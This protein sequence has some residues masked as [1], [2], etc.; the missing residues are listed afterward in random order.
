MKLIMRLKALSL[1]LINTY[2]LS[3]ELTLPV[4]LKSL[5]AS[6]TASVVQ[7]SVAGPCGHDEN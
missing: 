5:L 3:L 4:L 7:Q 6:Q 2:I 1:E